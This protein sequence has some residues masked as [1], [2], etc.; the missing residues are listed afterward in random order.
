MK[1]KILALTIALCFVTLTGAFAQV[2]TAKSTAKPQ[3]G[4]KPFTS[5][6]FNLQIPPKWKVD[7]THFP[8][9]LVINLPPDYTVDIPAQDVNL[10]ISKLYGNAADEYKRVIANE[11]KNIKSNDAKAVITE[12]DI[13]YGPF[14]TGHLITYVSEGWTYEVAFWVFDNKSYKAKY[15]TDSKIYKKNVDNVHKLLDTWQIN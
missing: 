8:M 12:K 6:N 15:S 14:N 10:E 13:T 7:T 2:A 11:L 3:T 1:A 5:T 9:I 4:W